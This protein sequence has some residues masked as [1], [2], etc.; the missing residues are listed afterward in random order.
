MKKLLTQLASW[1][2][3]KKHAE[4][5]PASLRP[6]TGKNGQQLLEIDVTK[7]A[8]AGYTHCAEL[9]KIDTD[10]LSL[11]FSRQKLNATTMHLLI[12]LANECQLAT[13]IAA[14]M[15]GE[16]VNKSENRAALHTA[17][18]DLTAQSIL[19]DGKNIIPDLLNARTKMENIACELSAGQWLGYTG[20]PITSVVNIGIG[21]SDFGPRFCLHALND[22]INP[23]LSYH[24][25]S[26]ASPTAFDKTVVHLNPETTLFIISSKSFTTVETI[27][28]AK[29][30]LAWFGKTDFLHLHFIAVTANAAK[31]CEMGIRNILPIWDFIGGRYSFC[32]AINLISC[33]A[34]GPAQFRQL[35]AGARSMDHHFYHNELSRN[36][37]VLLALIGLWNINFRHIPSLLILVYAKELEQFVSYLQQLDMES[38]GKSIDNYGRVINYATGPIVWGG[39]GN[40]AQHSYFQ[41]LSQGSHRVAIDFL[42]IGEFDDCLIN[43]LFRN[44]MQALNS[45]VAI[46]DN[47]LQ[48]N[49]A[50]TLTINHLNLNSWNPYTLGEL[51]ALYE[52]KI[53]SQAVLWDINSFDQ[54]GVECIKKE[55]VF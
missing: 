9:F 29:K 36:M 33:I 52:H 45:G 46:A 7:K 4:I 42:T 49:N 50:N 25:I 23:N 19:V 16:K 38:N 26:D 55:L 27:Y 20:R 31:A 13:K 47:N 34:I 24:F 54:P 17:L 1:H 21:G 15:N 41:L 10:T 14:L 39:L 28:N 35:L 51:V 40:Q 43:K 22:W 3:L 12:S 8:A 6:Q 30:A 18:R 53:F 37:P 11:D 2:A 48:G 5:L 44:S 32:S